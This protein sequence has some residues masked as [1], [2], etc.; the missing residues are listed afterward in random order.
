MLIRNE[1]AIVEFRLELKVCVH[2]L[3]QLVH[4]SGPSKLV[5]RITKRCPKI[6]NLPLFYNAFVVNI[7]QVFSGIDAHGFWMVSER[8][9]PV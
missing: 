7:E 8:I 5:M 1:V 6:D 4:Q 2:N 9:E 3:V